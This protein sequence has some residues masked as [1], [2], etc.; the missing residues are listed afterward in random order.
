M[1]RPAICRRHT[2]GLKISV[3]LDSARFALLNTSRAALCVALFC[4]TVAT[5]YGFGATRCEAQMP[6]ET[7]I[8]MT[9]AGEQVI[10]IEVAETSEQK[11]LG[12]MFRTAMADSAGMLFPYSPA[13]ELM[14]WMKNTYI[15]LDMVFIRADGVVH[16]IQPRTEPLSEKTVSSEGEVTAVLE[17][18]GG[19]AM[20][21]GLKP[22]DR[23]RHAHFGTAKK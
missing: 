7:L 3:Q 9:A 11:A 14:M 5:V 15:S 19:A 4:F 10:N 12:L 2:D 23:V 8:L 16:R 22:G 13:Q 20:R 21:L 18:A 6:R 17:L 1:D